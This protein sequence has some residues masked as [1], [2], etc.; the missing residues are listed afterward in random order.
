MQNTTTPK[1]IKGVGDDECSDNLV[2]GR[3]ALGGEGKGEA[4]GDDD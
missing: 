4:P 3:A 2:L 1:A